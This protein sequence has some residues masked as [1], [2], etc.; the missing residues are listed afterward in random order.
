[1]IPR[2]DCRRLQMAKGRSDEQHPLYFAIRVTLDVVPDRY[3][4]QLVIG[5]LSE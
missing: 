2:R 1:M 5:S 3:Y 4:D